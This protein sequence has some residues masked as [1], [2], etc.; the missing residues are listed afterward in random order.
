MKFI[1]HHYVCLHVTNGFRLVS[2]QVWNEDVFNFN[3]YFATDQFLV[4]RMFL[5][6]GLFFLL[7]VLVYIKKRVYK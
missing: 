3:I 2:G 5:S 4:F 7:M 6:F 1:P